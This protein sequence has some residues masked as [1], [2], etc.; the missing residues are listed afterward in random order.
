M[1]TRQ[2]P[3]GASEALLR[4]IDQV[5]Q[6]GEAVRV[7]AG[8][9]PQGYRVAE[10]Y[11]IVP[12]AARARFLVPLATR[13]AAHA[14]LSRYNGLRPGALGLARALL[15]AAFRVGLAPIALRDE[16][17]VCLAEDA[18]PADHLIVAHL[19]RVLGRPGLAAGIGVRPVDP[20]GKPTLQLFQPDGTPAGY[21]K[22]GWNAAT[23]R[24]VAMEAEALT[25]VR[26]V[27]APRLLYGGSRRDRQIT[28]TEPLPPRIRAH[29]NPDEPP[30]P[31]V[32]AAIAAGSGVR[33]TELAASPY[34]QAVRREISEIDDEPRLRRALA[35]LA[36]RLEG[37][38]GGTRLRFG[39]WHGDLVPWNLGR[40]DGTLHIWDWEHSAT[41]V[42][43]GFD[44]LHW[45]FQVALVL[46][47]RPLAEAVAAVHDTARTSRVDAPPGL[48]AQAYLLEIFLRT[49]RLQR[50]GGGWNTDLYPAMF[51]VLPK[52]DDGV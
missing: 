39:R 3:A 12:N 41:G 14:S 4:L 20:N 7:T 36:V 9:T 1:A 30:G 5:W 35:T 2:G 25:A 33:E 10:R 27:T 38:Y 52:G 21:A 31:D 24:L 32:L 13:A 47:R 28:V 18:D 34:W 44:L 29:R 40:H 51:D 43:I 15:G 6:P 17:T 37:E 8:E 48:L 26:G 45:H 49:H 22:I 46:R 50:G 42:P 19:G 23:R 16:L 11:S